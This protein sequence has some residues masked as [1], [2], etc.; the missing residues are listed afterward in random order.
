MSAPDTN[1]KRQAR[2][3]RPPLIGIALVVGFAAIAMFIWLA[4]EASEGN[5]PGEDSVVTDTEDVAP[6]VAIEET[7]P[8]AEE[9]PGT[10][11]N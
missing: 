2:R 7:A 8:A 9:I 4:W 11:G 5:T 3:H 1:V 6:G 10:A